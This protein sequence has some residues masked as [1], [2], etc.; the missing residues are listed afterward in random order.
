MRKISGI[1]LLDKPKLNKETTGK[2]TVGPQC[3]KVKNTE[4]D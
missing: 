1:K 3:L 2:S 4:Y